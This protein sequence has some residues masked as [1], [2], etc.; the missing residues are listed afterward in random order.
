MGG[1]IGVTDRALVRTDM[2]AR[3]ESIV[4]ACPGDAGDGGGDAAGV[5]VV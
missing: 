3:V 2:S 1:V 5:W 4:M